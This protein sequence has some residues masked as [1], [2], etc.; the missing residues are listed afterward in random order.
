MTTATDQDILV[1]V[2][3]IVA[4][5]YSSDSSPLLLAELGSRLGSGFRPVSKTLTQLIAAANDPDL[6]LIRDK[7]TPAYVVVTTST[8]RPVVEEWLER[9]KQATTSVPDLWDLPRSVLLAF[10]VPTECDKQVYISKAHPFKYEIKAKEADPDPELIAVEDRYRRPGLKILDPKSLS[11]VDQ[12]DLQTKIITWSKDK[13]IPLGRFNVPSWK[14][15]TNALERLLAA[16][17]DG[18]S[19]KI[20]I[21]GDIALFLLRHE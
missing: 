1:K 9:R 2:R 5:H 3:G 10:C 17:R 18:I 16:Q 20:L 12:L 19:D 7:N 11:A 4:D 13:N 14:K 6:L 8:S 15:S 21:P